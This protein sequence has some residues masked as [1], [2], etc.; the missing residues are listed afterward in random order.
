MYL[1]MRL[2]EEEQE[3]P[4]KIV[5]EWQHGKP[6]SPS[7]RRQFARMGFRAVEKENVAV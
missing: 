4:V 2:N 3:R 6:A 7:A 5:S 1:P